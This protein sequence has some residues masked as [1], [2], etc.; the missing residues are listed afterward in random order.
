MS[1]N[2]KVLPLNDSQSCL[3][4]TAVS[5]ALNNIASGSQIHRNC[6]HHA[7][8][9]NGG[10]QSCWGDGHVCAPQVCVRTKD[11]KY[12]GICAYPEKGQY[13][14]GK[15]VDGGAAPDATPEGAPTSNEG[16]HKGSKFVCG[17]YYNS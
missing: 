17:C 2:T 15:M 4:G 10:L 14:V 12:G 3:F 6:A 1:F 8:T 11:T 16:K 9:C 7:Q 13:V 5:T